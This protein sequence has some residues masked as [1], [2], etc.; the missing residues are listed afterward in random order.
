MK[1]KLLLGAAL[2]TMLVGCTN[3][4]DPTDGQKPGETGD[5]YIAVR[6]N[7]PTQKGSRANDVFDD[8][9]LNEY[10]VNNAALVLFCGTQESSATFVGAYKLGDFELPEDVSDNPNQITTSYIAVQEVSSFAKGQNDH[11]YALVLVNYDGVASI[12][13][14]NLTMGTVTTTAGTTTIS[15]LVAATTDHAFYNTVLTNNFFMTNAPLSTLAGGTSNPA[16]ASL[17]T[18]ADLGTA[19]FQATKAAAHKAP[20]GV[21]NVERAVAKASLVCDVT[22]TTIPA[23]HEIDQLTVESVEWVLD[24]CEKNSYFIRNLDGKFD[25][26]KSYK[27]T[28]SNTYR[29]VGSNPISTGEA[30]HR[31]YWCVDPNY[32]TD[33][34]DAQKATR[35]AFVAK[36]KVQY[37]HENTFDVAHMTHKNTTRAILKIT[38]SKNGTTGDLYVLA[39]DN[40]HIYTDYDNEIL[41]TLKAYLAG[42]PTIVGKY[43][44]LAP[45]TDITSGIT[46]TTSKADGKATVTD[47]VLGDVDGVTPTALDA[48][49]VTALCAEVNAFHPVTYYADGVAYHEVYFKHFGDDDAKWTAP[50]ADEAAANTVTGAYGDP[51]SESEYLGRWGMVR[52][53]WYQLEITAINNIGYATIPEV[54]DIPD[55]NN[56]KWIG[57]QIRVLS[58]AKR[59]QE[60]TL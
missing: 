12:N 44:G 46:L 50:S 58:W 4:E 1:H 28:T 38:Y 7:L 23:D 34:A 56:S 48:A 8:G 19:P 25:T 30:A 39:G 17:F 9:T 5:G 55:D 2:A 15:D 53:N 32:A 20:A 54:T 51:V 43:A 29:M 45:G 57:V 16:S 18:L 27:N 21:I 10:Q 11:V 42:N 14:T 26:W 52:N 49:E 40:T 13:G 3:V 35:G 41:P 60:E 47:I 22:A 6:L 36:D 33:L 59:S 37:C 24:N 31:T